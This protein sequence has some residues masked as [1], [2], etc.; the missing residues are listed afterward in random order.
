MRLAGVSARDGDKMSFS[1]RIG[2]FP[3]CDR[4]RP[5]LLKVTLVIV[6]LLVPASLKLTVRLLPLS[7][8]TP[9]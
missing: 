2:T 5:V 3:I 6:S 9:L 4:P 1:R 8:L 7:R